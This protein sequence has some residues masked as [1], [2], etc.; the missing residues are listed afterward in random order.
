MD[1]NLGKYIKTLEEK[2]PDCG[3]KLQL[4]LKDSVEYGYCQMC[5]YEKKLP[6][7]E[8]GRRRHA[9]YKKRGGTKEYNGA[10]GF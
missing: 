8:K 10:K 9:D 1:T 6:Y 4:R 2:C 7:K 3:S 5:S